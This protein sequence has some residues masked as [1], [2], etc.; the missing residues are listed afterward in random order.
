MGDEWLCAVC[1]RFQ[2]LIKIFP[3]PGTFLNRVAGEMFYA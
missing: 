2:F 3:I 1:S